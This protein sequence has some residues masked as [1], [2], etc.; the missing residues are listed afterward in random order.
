MVDNPVKE[1]AVLEP[2]CLEERVGEA[3][4]NEREWDW[5]AYQ[6]EYWKKHL[7]EILK[8][9]EIRYESGRRRDSEGNAVLG[10][11]D[12]FTKDVS[13]WPVEV[14][15]MLSDFFGYSQRRKTS[16]AASP[17]DLLEDLIEERVPAHIN[18]TLIHELTHRYGGGVHLDKDTQKAYYDIITKILNYT[19]HDV[20]KSAMQ[21]WREQ[22]GLTTEKDIS[23]YC[24][25]QEPEKVRG[26]LESIKKRYE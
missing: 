11:C 20:Y 22:Y 25:H 21:I 13:V 7:E 17:E 24:R 12:P 26:F 15:L 2:A 3:V 6:E 5:H 14:L 8:R 4:S 9:S 18:E 19:R 16:P 10:E 23:D 1:G